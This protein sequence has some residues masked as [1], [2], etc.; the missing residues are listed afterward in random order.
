[1]VNTHFAEIAILIHEGPQAGPDQSWWMPPAH[2]SGRNRGTTCTFQGRCTNQKLSSPRN[3]SVSWLRPH[4][5]ASGYPCFA[6]LFEIYPLVY[7]EYNT[8]WPS[9]ENL[10]KAVSSSCINSSLKLETL[11]CSSAGEWANKMC[12][13]LTRKYYSAIKRS[14]RYGWIL[15]AC[16]VEEAS[17]KSPYC[18]IPF[19]RSSK[20]TQPI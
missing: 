16:Q 2:P 6:A 9:N 5:M 1:M 19:K 17:H 8:L 15:N 10:C 14:K 13:S 12:C 7:M 4:C 18:R 3:S 11:Q 20:Q